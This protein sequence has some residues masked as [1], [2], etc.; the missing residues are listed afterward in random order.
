MDDSQLNEAQERAIKKLNQK[1]EQRLLC[2]SVQPTLATVY[3]VAGTNR[4]AT[5]SGISMENVKNRMLYGFERVV[6]I[7]QSS[8]KCFVSQD[9]N[10]NMTDELLM[11]DP[12]E[13]AQIKKFNLNRMRRA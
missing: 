1:I 10:G 12:H 8:G 5:A 9:A 7:Q 4:G 6:P 11:A 2:Q 3:P 13:L